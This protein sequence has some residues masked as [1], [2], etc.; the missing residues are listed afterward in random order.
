LRSRQT[1]CARCAEMLMLRIEFVLFWIVL[2]FILGL[3]A[4]RMGLQAMHLL[5]FLKRVVMRLAGLGIG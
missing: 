4:A 1:V 5:R 3:V 2:A